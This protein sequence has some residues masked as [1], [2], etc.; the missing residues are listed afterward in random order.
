MDQQDYQ[1]QHY[2]LQLQQQQQQ[3]LQQRRQQQQ[4][5]QQS[6]EA[7]PSAREFTVVA[8]GR[9]GEGTY[10]F[11]LHSDCNATKKKNKRGHVASNVFMGFL[12]TLDYSFAPFHLD[13]CLLFRLLT[14]W[15][16]LKIGKSTL[17]N[18]IL[19]K[20]MFLTKASVSVSR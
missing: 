3:E 12:V 14:L 15:I 1:Y 11:L 7:T 9:S 4:Q 17:L 2:M 18:S 19:G 8:L 16:L 13:D 10:C 20:E 5:Q 6:I